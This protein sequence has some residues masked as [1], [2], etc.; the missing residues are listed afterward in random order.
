MNSLIEQLNQLVKLQARATPGP[1]V[2][3][4]RRGGDPLQIEQPDERGAFVAY[5]DDSEPESEDNAA[6]IAAAGSLNFAALCDALNRPAG[7]KEE[8][9]PAC[10]RCQYISADKAA[11]DCPL[12][13][14]NWTHDVTRPAGTLDGHIKH[15][16]AALTPPATSEAG[17]AGE[18]ADNA[19]LKLIGALKH[20]I[21]VA[22]IEAA[23]PVYKQA[24]AALEELMAMAAAHPATPAPVAAGEAEG[25]AWVP[26]AEWLPE[27]GS[28]VWA[29]MLPPNNKRKVVRSFFRPDGI[30]DEFCPEWITH[31]QPYY[32]A[33]PTPPATT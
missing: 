27:K 10:N 11:P 1:W 15:I 7:L 17:G 5:A 32:V 29:A 28:I 30:W 8:T 31:W 12:C 6:F 33:E 18:A 19:S 25:A 3:A 9:F 21:S 16:R 2:T 24:I 14:G 13:R 20:L 23:P 4:A 22:C 26:V